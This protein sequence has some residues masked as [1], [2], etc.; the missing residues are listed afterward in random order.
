MRNSLLEKFVHLNFIPTYGQLEISL[1]II[2]LFLPIGAKNPPPKTNCTFTSV[3]CMIFCEETKFSSPPQKKKN[4]KT[5]TIHWATI[6]LWKNQKK[7]INPLDLEKQLHG[8]SQINGIYCIYFFRFLNVGRK[9]FLFGRK[10]CPLKKREVW[11]P[12]KRYGKFTV[13][14]KL[15]PFLGEAFLEGG[16]TSLLPQKNWKVH[17]Y[18]LEDVTFAILVWWLYSKF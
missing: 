14:V 11:G 15:G 16:V 6:N 4:K 12:Q 2:R 18:V 9:N 13:R 7:H 10:L 1:P 17:R 8:K 3:R 5:K